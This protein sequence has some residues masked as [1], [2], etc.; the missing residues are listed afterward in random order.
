M[1][2]QY[3]YICVHELVPCLLTTALIG[4]QGTRLSTIMQ[5]RWGTGN[6][7]TETVTL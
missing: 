6:K 4:S 2:H 3:Q 5:A 1:L 7:A